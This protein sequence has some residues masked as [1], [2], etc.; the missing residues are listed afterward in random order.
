MVPALWGLFLWCLLPLANARADD[1]A[2]AAHRRDFPKTLTF[3]EP[4][5]DDEMSLPTIVRLP[6]AA[7]DGQG[8]DI[9]VEL[10][11]RI[12]ERVSVQINTGYSILGQRGASSLTGWQ[13]L[14]AT[15]KGIALDDGP[16]ERLVSVS[17]EREFGGT[18]AERVGAG[19]PSATT[20]AVNFGQGLGGF[21]ANRLL[22]PFAVT[23]SVG[24][25]IPDRTIAPQS[26]LLDASLQYSLGPWIPLVEFAYA[27]P[28]TTVPGSSDSRRGTLAPG[29]IYAGEGYQLAA[30]ALIPLTRAT[31]VHPGF[32]AQLNLSL[33]WLGWAAL[34]RPLF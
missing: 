20:A 28:A 21:T 7:P 17:L 15:L 33:G 29:L 4:G 14:A 1:D 31:G 26:L 13:N 19:A 5:I 24:Y 23:G 9:S 10:D 34:T 30:E 25:Q 22:A 2:A 16:A 11:K 8:A 12:T 6:H 32:V 3:D 27:L 18:G